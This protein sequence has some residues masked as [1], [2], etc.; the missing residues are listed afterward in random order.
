[1]RGFRRGRYVKKRSKGQKKIT[2]GIC[3]VIFTNYEILASD[4]FL[5]FCKV[6]AGI[7]ASVFLNF[8]NEC[9]DPTAGIGKK[10]AE[11]GG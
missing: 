6:W 4:G 8:E 10:C 9:A 2:A 7:R 3:V 1:M 11:P 5:L